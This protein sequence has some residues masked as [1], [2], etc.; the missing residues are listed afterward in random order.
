MQRHRG[1]LRRERADSL[2]TQLLNRQLHHKIQ[3]IARDAEEEDL[4]TEMA[5]NLVFQCLSLANNTSFLIKGLLDFSIFDP[6]DNYRYINIRLPMESPAVAHNQNKLYA[7]S[8]LSLFM[9]F[10]LIPFIWV[11]I[12]L[13][14]LLLL[15]V[16]QHQCYSK[17]ELNN[18][19]PFFPVFKKRP[20]QKEVISQEYSAFQT[21]LDLTDLKEKHNVILTNTSLNNLQIGDFIY[22][23][24][25]DI[26]PTD[27]LLLYSNETNSTANIQLS[28][29]TFTNKFTND[30]FV[31]LLR[32][33]TGLAN[34]NYHLHYHKRSGYLFVN[35]SSSSS[36]SSSYSQKSYLK[37][38]NIIQKGSIINSNEIIGL[39]LD[40]STIQSNVFKRSYNK[41]H[42]TLI[43]PLD[44]SS[45]FAT[46]YE[47]IQNTFSKSLP[48]PHSNNFTIKRKRRKIIAFIFAFG[49][50]R[51]IFI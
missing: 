22:L 1:E 30:K 41:I 14:T 25:N 35:S 26:V 38:E 32:T 39:I 2:R 9:L 51:L 27:I 43:K 5:N 17:K 23:K 3:E 18:E 12:P 15:I 47:T 4:D 50:V 49:F 29:N 13:V 44:F 21:T 45:S 7:L 6:K 8:F 10:F 46:Y 33:N 42:N 28:D 11:I 31:N 24:K 37:D 19:E 20:L 48:I 40:T 36:T 16:F 34:I